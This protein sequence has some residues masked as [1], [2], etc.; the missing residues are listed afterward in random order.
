M[1]ILSNFKKI[2]EVIDVLEKG[3]L[4]IVPTE[5]I[6]GIICDSN[7]EG[8]V[9]KLNKYKQRPFGKPYAVMV[10]SLG[11]AEEYAELNQT[12]KNLYGEFLPGPLTV[13]SKGK[14]KVASGIESETGSLG[15]RIPDYPDLLKL[16]SEFGRPVVA[17]R[18]N[19]N[20]QKLPYKV[21]DVLKSISPKQKALID[22]I[23]DVGTLPKNELSTVIDTT[24]DDPAV[25]RQGEIKLKE[26]D[27]VVSK[28][29]KD[30]ENLAKR[31]WQKYKTYK[32]KRAII[33]ALEGPM[34]AGKTQFVK[35]LAKAMGIK[36]TITSPSYE[37]V[38]SYKFLD[39]IDTW[40]MLN[41]ESELSELGTQNFIDD[42]DVLAIEWA[43]KVV[44]QIKKYSDD[45]VVIWLK[46]SYGDSEKE[47]IINWGVL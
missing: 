46:I 47:R 37:L 23:V 31:L 5:T 16:I 12:A 9:R 26:E 24:L 27:K 1:K 10:N 38:S 25:L 17:T 22:L 35:G 14:S 36:E 15:V 11:M 42:K 43:D 32:G 44:K 8:A 6:Y 40:R 7:N 28:S 4:V 2:N 39:H 33:F 41:P 20:Y 18:S 30:T 13:V 3:G 45:A 21:D 34:G 29:E 19:A